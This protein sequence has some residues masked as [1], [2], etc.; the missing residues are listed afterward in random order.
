MIITSSR[1][2]PPTDITGRIVL[3][4]ALNTARGKLN[5]RTISQPEPSSEYKCEFG[6]AV[7]MSSVVFSIS[8]AW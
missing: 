5:S 1:T 7:F 8:R 4:T 6:V 3:R 2:L